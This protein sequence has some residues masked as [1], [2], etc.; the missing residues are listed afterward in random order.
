MEIQCPYCGKVLQMNHDDGSW[1]EQEITHQFNCEH[2][3][4]Y[5]VFT[6]HVSFSFSTQKADCLNDGKHNYKLTHTFPKE[7]SMMEC[8]MCGDRRNLTNEE[9]K[10]FQIGSVDDYIKSLKK[11]TS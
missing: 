3:E 9:K 7:L 5:F 4:K 11:L 2:C 10:Q 1:Y 6:T 8:E